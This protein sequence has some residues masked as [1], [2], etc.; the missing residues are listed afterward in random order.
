MTA[1]ASPPVPVTPAELGR[2][3]AQ[4]RALL[5]MSRDIGFIL[6]ADKLLVQ[7]IESMERVFGYRGASIFLKDTATATY[8]TAACAASRPSCPLHHQ[9]PLDAPTL[10]A[11][12]FITGEPAYILDNECGETSAESICSELAVPLQ[13][14]D[15][16][17][18]VLDL[19]D[20]EART[21]SRQ[22]LQ[23]IMAVADQVSV[24]LHNARLYRQA[25][26]RRQVA[27]TMAWVAQAVN[28]SLDLDLV[29]DRALEYL[30]EVVPYNSAAI[31]LVEGRNLVVTAARGF[32]NAAEII[33]SVY[34][35][36]AQK[37]IGHQVMESQQVR[38]E[39]DVQTLADWGRDDI[40]PDTFTLI[41]S[42]IGAPLVFK[43][44]TLGLLTIDKHEPNFY[45][46]EHGQLAG[47]IADQI[48]VAVQ[49][50]RLYQEAREHA[51]EMTLLYETAQHISAVLDQDALLAEIIAQVRR[52]FGYQIV[53]IHL[54]DEQT[55]QLV[56]AAHHGVDT[57]LFQQALQ[58]TEGEGVVFWV[59]RHGQTALLP[60]V[61][62]DARYV[63]YAVG[64]RS[65][66]TIPLIGGEQAIGVFNVESEQ[67]NA[68][69]DNAVRLLTALTHQI[70]GALVNARLFANVRRQ[71]AALAEM[72]HT[73]KAEKSTL[74][75][76]LRNIA[77]AL[78]V[79]A[80][81]GEVIL[82]NPAFEYMFDRPATEIL[83]NTLATCIAQPALVRLIANA[84]EEHT[85]TF[86]AEIP[87]PARRTCKAAATAIREE[88]QIL[89]VVTVVRDVTHEKAVEMMKTEFISA[90]SHELRTPLT[91]VLGFTKLI[92]R[93]VDKDIVPATPADNKRA[94]RAL[95]RV[96]TNLDIIAVESE[97]LT[98]LINDVLDIS[99]MESG[100]V[101]WHDEPFDLTTLLHQMA[102]EAQALAADKELTVI[103]KLPDA[104]LTLVAD[105]A[106]VRQVLHNLL[107]NAVKFT[108]AGQISLT[109]RP[110][111]PGEVVHH[112]TAPD[113]P[114][115]GAAPYTGVLCTVADT[116]IGIPAAALPRLFQRFQQ[117][118]G[119]PLVD[120]PSGTGLGLAI[121][122]EIVTHYGGV[123]WAESAAGSGAIFNFAL[124]LS[125]PR[126]PAGASAIIAAARPDLL[127]SATPP[128]AP[129]ILIVEDDASVRALLA[130]ELTEAGYRP[131]E[132][133]S[134][135]EALMLGRR[136]LPRLIVL[137][138]VL[139]DISG[140]DVM[141]V[142]KADAGT[143]S[144]PILILSGGENRELGLQL[145]AAAYLL[146]PPPMPVL[147]QTIAA[148]LD[149]DAQGENKLYE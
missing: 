135:V 68:F 5:D 125:P 144:I 93:I 143:A 133:G 59:L 29:L 108:P 64:I 136:Y 31:M 30:A 92:R 45:T 51:K 9:Q 145:G 37:N 22:D 8:Y 140:F 127:A 39:D 72:T 106:R 54:V 13:I 49:N 100:K 17:V 61:T 149:R 26:N 148:L 122:R 112:W 43:G 120:K 95:R 94:Q 88:S 2:D 86:T 14:N 60:D 27:A 78:I 119:D 21:F 90:V 76:I 111:L 63:P 34:S 3:R 42:W 107:T 96:G 101:T 124:P 105:Q 58:E 52:V 110:L 137:D 139:P 25:E 75:A 85:A 18:G 12:V 82:V 69:D 126:A 104:P 130:Q 116:G 117:I 6:D 10:V 41:R 56:L 142:L 109:L 80:P 91:S 138:I 103:A 1:E 89:G 132:T 33:G 77:D 99:K 53:S 84:L 20:P 67:L 81:D 147:L 11:Q 46:A 97:R 131:L 57:A 87:L 55:G 113:P 38:I 35:Q 15:E 7:V 79:S 65:E 24:A 71:A 121:S 129:L 114:A 70:A 36:D 83:G 146:K 102:D 66:L 48:A 4:L 47:A 44:C 118:V 32:S 98:R 50:A 123:I 128:E 74:N 73:L 115:D 40:S 141:R 23:T 134:G 28:S 19:V 62:R 16:T